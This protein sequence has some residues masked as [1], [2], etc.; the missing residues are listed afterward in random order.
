MTSTRLAFVAAVVA[1]VLGSSATAQVPSTTIGPVEKRAKPITPENPIPRRIHSVN[2]IYPVE[3][4]AIGASGRVSV[5]AVLDEFGRVAE[6]RQLSLPILAFSPQTAPDP[7]ALKMATEAVLRSAAQ[8]VQQ[9]QYDSPADGPIAFNVTFSLTPGTPGKIAETASGG[10]QET[11]TVRAGAAGTPPP[12]PPPPPVPGAPTSTP[13][14]SWAPPQGAV[15]VGGQIRA[16]QQLY[17]AN[18]VYPLEAQAARVQ[19]VVILE[20]VIGTDGRVREARILRSIPLLDQAALDAVRQWQYTPTMLNGA[21][22]PVIMTVTVQFT[23]A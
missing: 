13:T 18:P 10:L 23:L 2:P 11:L 4:T 20:A 3:A 16:P 21:P 14:P 12:P 1:L 8:A 5:R 9:W 7:T 19:G 17:K 22:V 6:V 15:R